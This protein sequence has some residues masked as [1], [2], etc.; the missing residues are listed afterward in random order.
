M[1]EP[2]LSTTI[3][4]SGYG[5]VLAGMPMESGML[6]GMALI[7]LLGRETRNRDLRELEVSS[8]TLY[9]PPLSDE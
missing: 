7:A 5:C 4:G 1:I 2:T 9:R 3:V 6:W 8:A